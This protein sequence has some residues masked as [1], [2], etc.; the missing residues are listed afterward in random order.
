MPRTVA[1]AFLAVALL[2][3]CGSAAAPG[4]LAPWL[5][6]P[7]REGHSRFFPIAASAGA[8]PSHAAAGC[9]DCH[10]GF[11]T[12]KQFTCL[13]CHLQA[14]TAAQHP[15]VPGYAYDSNSC[16]GCHANG[17]ASFPGHDAIFPISA[18]T[19]HAGIGCSKCHTVPGDHAPA[20]QGC[21]SCHTQA[22][23][24]PL[25]GNVGG[26]T[27]AV[28]A[29]LRC[30]ADGQVNLVSGHAPFQI[31]S[32]AAHFQKSCLVCHPGMRTDKAWG[33]DFKSN[34][35]L[36]C[37]AQ[38]GT[39]AI[40]TTVTGYAYAT[41]SCLQ[42]HPKGTTDPPATHP[43]LFPIDAASKHAA[44]YCYQCHTDFTAPRNAANFACAACH[45]AKDP[46]IGTKHATAT[47][48]VTDFAATSVMC[49]KCHADSQVNLT[50][51]HSTG[52]GTPSQNGTHRTAGCTTCHVDMR[53]DKTFG[54]DFLK[55]NGCKACH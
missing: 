26:Y 18:G 44:V 32:P 2:A 31:Q 4:T 53:A 38:A 52:D 37:H 13:T 15:G 28:A 54:L 3:G 42:C 45:G 7:T 30:H 51:N 24:A 50:K 17:V 21:T 14:P 39:A 49:L 43:A 40:H 35:C 9:N 11:D 33:A 25:H 20:T 19:L 27:W 47:I 10:G 46:A 6:A 1:P 23:T 55:A 12:F 29:C 22:A 8:T 34:D 36:A 41:A 48:P 16:Y 5:T